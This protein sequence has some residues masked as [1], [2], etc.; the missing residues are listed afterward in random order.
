[1]PDEVD[2]D[3]D[4]RVDC[5]LADEA[6]RLFD[7]LA[8]LCLSRSAFDNFTWLLVADSRC[9]WLLLV[10]DLWLNFFLKVGLFGN[11]K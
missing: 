7:A 2:D 1:M 6:K 3:N 10:V 5:L 9:F 11:E 8:I 4:D